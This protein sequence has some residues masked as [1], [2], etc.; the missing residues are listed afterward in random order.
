LLHVHLGAERELGERAL[1][2]GVPE[3]RAETEDSRLVRRRDDRDVP[4]RSLVV[5]VGSTSVTQKYCPGWKSTSPPR[6]SKTTI[7]VPFATSVFSLMRA[8]MS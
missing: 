7:S 3:A 8:C 5:V 2:R 1:E 6:R 4:A